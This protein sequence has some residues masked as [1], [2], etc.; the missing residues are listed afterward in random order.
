[1]EKNARVGVGVF[2]F[3]NGKFLMVQRRG[4]HEAGTWACPGGYLEFGESFEQTAVREVR[5]E[6]GLEIKNI[7]FGAVTNDY[8]KTE[9]KHHITIW[10]LSDWASGQ[11]KIL[12]PNKCEKQGWFDFDSLP[13][14]LFLAWKQLL[15]SQFIN[16]IKEE[17]NSSKN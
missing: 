5:E 13:E 14:P 3:K 4:S 2:I 15:S 11:E 12:E 17:L 6:T 7:R 9:G 10:L 8:F 1:M 16:P